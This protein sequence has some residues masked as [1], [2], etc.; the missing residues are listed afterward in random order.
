LLSAVVGYVD[1]VMDQ[2]GLRLITSY[3]P[4][5]EAM[6]RRRLDDGAGTRFVARL[7]GVSLDGAAYDRGTAFVAG[8]LERAGEE[9]LARLWH[10]AKELPTPAEIAAP[11][12]WLARIDLPDD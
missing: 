10:S 7:L 12:L 6:R 4:L 2:V 5:T 9:G 1:H 3:G 8:V 11:G